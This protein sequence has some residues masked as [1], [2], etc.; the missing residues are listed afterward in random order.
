MGDS[1]C[2]LLCYPMNPGSEYRPVPVVDA[3]KKGPK[4]G[5]GLSRKAC[6][7]QCTCSDME[8]GWK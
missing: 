4:R 3:R 8:I 6:N 5:T 7:L 2:R 1:C